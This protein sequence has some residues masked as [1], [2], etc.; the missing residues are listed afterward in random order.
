M[1]FKGR[2][3]HTNSSGQVSKP[4]QKGVDQFLV[5]SWDY[6]ELF[7]IPV[8]SVGNHMRIRVEQS[9][10]K[11]PNSNPAGEFLFDKRWPLNEPRESVQRNHKDRLKSDELIEKL[12]QQLVDLG[13]AV[14]RPIDDSACDLLAR[15]DEGRVVT[16]TVRTTEV[17]DGHAYFNPNSNTSRSTPGRD[18]EYYLLYC[19]D[20]DLTL[21]LDPDEVGTAV[22]LWIDD[23]NEIKSKTRFADD[24]ELE[25]A[26]PPDDVPTVSSKTP[27]GA[28]RDAF[29]DIDVTVAFV[30]DDDTPADLL[31]ERSDGTFARV[32][33]VPVWKNRSGC[34]RLKPDR[35]EGIDCYAAYDRE[36]DTC[37]LVAA[38]AFDRSIS[39]RVDDPDEHTA[40]I[41][42]ADDYRLA[43]AWPV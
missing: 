26:W 30:T 34:L 25:T 39:L 24:Y 40:R 12:A 1:V 23:P 3:T 8:E 32:A 15:I 14:Y 36:E 7:V 9:K 31:A 20:R 11:T 10:Q 41:N 21:L 19:R 13:A 17:T 43:D 18:T 27:S 28:V 16:L 37:Y 4:Y 35:H 22:T 6:E 5:Y 2:S 29:G 42:W 33:A 38:D